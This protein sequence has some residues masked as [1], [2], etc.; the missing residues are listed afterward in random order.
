MTT[1][2]QL[3]HWLNPECAPSD[4]LRARMTDAIE[5]F[6]SITRAVDDFVA[7]HQATVTEA[8]AASAGLPDEVYSVVDA[9]SGYAQLHDEIHTLSDRLDDLANGKLSGIGLTDAEVGA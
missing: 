9:L 7:T 2:I 3:P 6:A 5:Q 4:E 1:T 8:H